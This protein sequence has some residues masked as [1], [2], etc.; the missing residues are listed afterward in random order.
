MYIFSE[1]VKDVPD[2]EYYL[3]IKA[4]YLKNVYESLVSFDISGSCNITI[5]NRSISRQFQMCC[6]LVFMGRLLCIVV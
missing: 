4:E 5:Q 2:K 1:L 3:K 6:L